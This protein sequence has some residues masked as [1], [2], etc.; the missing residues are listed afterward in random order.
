[1][2]DKYR[3][4]AHKLIYHPERVAQWRTTGDCYPIY[5]E[6]SPSGACN[7]RCTFCGLDFVG[8]QPRFLDYEILKVRLP[9]MG[10][11][12]V[13]SI[14]HSGEGEPLLN[15]HFA[16]ILRC[17]KES[18]IDQALATNAALLT[19]EK[20]EAILP[21]T[22]WIKVSIAGGTKEVYDALQ[23]GAKGDFEKVVDN[24][25]TAAEIKHKNGYHCTL[26]M[27]MLL[28]NENQHTAV[29]LA[30]IAKEIGADYL[31]IKPFSQQLASINTEYQDIKYD[32]CEKLA[33]ELAT[34]NTDHFK[35]I[36]RANTMANWDQ[37]EVAYPK[38][39]A[40]PFWSH[41]DAGGNVWGCGN[42]LHNENFC[43]GN[44]NES[45]FEEIWQGEKRQKHL[46]IMR[47]NWDISQCRVNCRM[48][49]INGYLNELENPIEHCNFI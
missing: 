1:V 47:E 26:G 38:C 23:R 20:A 7:H 6:L 40:L 37:A 30:K 29:S 27:Q 18:G 43:Y 10:Q 33:E 5:I 8:Y 28:L 22:E 42:F 15:K 2:A 4:D 13:K 39:L 31:V 48:D 36:F 11:L 14:L 34:L 46:A 41:I 12:G 9:E 49:K 25:Q 16:E 19:R 32:Q 45:T 17:G 21:F 44:I 35:V 24:I 3:I